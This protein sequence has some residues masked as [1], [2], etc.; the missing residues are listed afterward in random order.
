MRTAAQIRQD[1]L[2][3]FIQKHDHVFVPSSPVIPHEDPTL[4]FANAG[5]NQFKPCF[6]GTAPAG[7]E[8]ATLVRAA[9]TQKCIRAGGKHN[10]L[11]DVGTDTYHHTFFEM[12][13]NWSF[14]DYFKKEAIEW[15]WD[16]LTNVWGLD[17][18]RLY[19]TVFEGDEE[20]GLPADEEAEELW[21]SVTDIDPSHVRRFG[22]KDNFWEMGE[23]GPC[24]PCSEIHYDGSA[25]LSGGALV[26]ADHPDVIEIWNLVF[27]QFERQEDGSLKPLPAKHVDTG[28]GF[29]RI[30]RVLQGKTSNYETDLWTPLFTAIQKVTGARPYGG[31][32]DDS[33]DIAY[34][35]IAD[36]IR[37]L[38]FAITDGAQPSNEGRGYVLRRILRRAVRHGRQT[39]GVQGVFFADLVDAVVESLGEAFPELKKNP[40]HIIDVVRDEEESFGRTLD[41]GIALFEQAAKSEATVASK[42]IS[43]EDAFLLHDTFGFPIDLTE[44]MAGERGLSVDL[45]GYQ[46]RMEEAREL[47]R[48][49]GQG[50]SAGAK[51]ALTTEALSALKVQGIEPTDDA[52]KFAGMECTG[53]VLSLWDGSQFVER[54]H[55]HTGDQD[56]LVGLISDRTSFYANMGGQV[57]DSGVIT[58]DG[59]RFDVL[60]TQPAGNYILHIGTVVNG[61]LGVGDKVRLSVDASLRTPIMANHTATHML[62]RALREVLGA[63][64]EQKGSLVAEDRLRFDFSHGKA[65]THDELTAAQHLVNQDINEAMAV[66][67]EEV[68]LEK[69]KRIHGVRAVFGEVYPDPVRVVAIGAAVRDIVANPH[70]EKWQHHSIEFCGGTH[71]GSTNEAGAF[72]IVSEEAVAKGVRRIVALTGA[73][74]QQARDTAMALRERLHKAAA[75]P[76]EQLPQ[77]VA[78]INQALEQET[79]PVRQRMDLFGDLAELQTKVKSAQKKAAKSEAEQVLSQARALADTHAG[80]TLIIA[81]EGAAGSTIRSAMDVFKSKHPESAV[82]LAS[83]D[84]EA[85]KVAIMAHVPD[86]L[87]KR[88]LKAGDWVRHTAQAC[89]GKGG[90]RP[91]SAQAGGKEPH[92]LP[93]ALQAARSFAQEKLSS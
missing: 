40:Q 93:E 5:M 9:N 71:L 2:D 58:C 82:L 30:T 44:I 62:N 52:P 28:M 68:P 90:G 78:Q 1:F 8:L 21:K 49:A 86:P 10:D 3:F 50:D 74:A 79:L 87:I 33:V 13:G 88:G 61:R 63:H 36:H 59:A 19:A 35:I 66:D 34:R 4:L 47:A 12:L 27:I 75:L 92:K 29:E 20:L 89:G 65:L 26:N 24:G 18:N 42:Q 72:I 53:R 37:T 77:E 22:K 14:G 57:G 84:H 46:Q 54:A 41:R 23:I 69:A 7:S 70:H 55:P 85:S 48:A 56:G 11:D 17:K 43:G 39:L 25:D 45:D 91:D 76:V 6:L 80:E 60:D 32:L 73:A 51:L 83:A 64:I 16:L 31:V 15:A 67:A 38:S 81:L